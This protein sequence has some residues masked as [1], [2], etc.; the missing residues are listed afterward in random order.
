MLRVGT[1]SIGSY[2]IFAQII[3]KTNKKTNKNHEKVGAGTEKTLVY[4]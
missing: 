4:T 1:M 3:I 2:V